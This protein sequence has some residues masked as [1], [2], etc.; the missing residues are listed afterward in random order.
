MNPATLEVHVEH[1]FER[2]VSLDFL[3]NI[4][5]R[6]SRQH[7]NDPTMA[8]IPHDVEIIVISQ[9][10][11]GAEKKFWKNGHKLF[12]TLRY[13]NNSFYSGWL[14]RRLVLAYL[15]NQYNYFFVCAHFLY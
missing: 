9:V 12:P 13:D 4:L 3:P 1:E 15:R 14:E 11:L 6:Q 8:D 7:T 5:L 2:G 10:F